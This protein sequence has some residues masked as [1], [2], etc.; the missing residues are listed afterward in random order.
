MPIYKYRRI[1][2]RTGCERCRQGID[3]IQGRFHVGELRPGDDASGKFR[4]KIAG[5][6][7][8]A[9]AALKLSFEEWVPGRLPITR[10]LLEREIALSVSPTRPGASSASGELTLT[11]DTTVQLR[12]A[13]SSEARVVA[14]AEPGSS[15]PVTGR[16]SEYFRIRLGPQRHAWVRQAQTRPGGGGKARSRQRLLRPPQ[17]SIAGDQVRRTSAPELRLKGWA[18]HPDGLRDV[19]VFVGERKVAY[20][21]NSGDRGSERID[22]AVD[23]P[24]EGGAN[25]IFVIARHD[26]KVLGTETVFVRQTAP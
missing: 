20:V 3:V 21:P 1:D 22:F 18:E 19:M 23:I 4:L 2:N 11:G 15:F 24:L 25:R 9:E 5:R 7:P 10:K 6:F 16:L 26:D 14:T 8:H 17:I 12:E 13:P